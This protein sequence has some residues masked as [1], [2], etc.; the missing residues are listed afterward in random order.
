MKTLVST[1]TCWQLACNKLG[2]PVRE[3][4]IPPTQRLS[5]HERLLHRRTHDSDDKTTGTRLPG[6]RSVFKAFVLT[7]LC[8]EQNLRDYEKRSCFSGT[9]R[10]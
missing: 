7:L 10:S 3:R 8:D 5:N 4:L 2:T 6:P 1:S 9:S